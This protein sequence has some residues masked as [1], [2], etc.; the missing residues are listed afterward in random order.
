[1]G[2]T[3]NQK[4][5]A[6]KNE[7]KRKRI[8]IIESQK[9]KEQVENAFE[10]CFIPSYNERIHGAIPV[11]KIKPFTNRRCPNCA[12]YPTLKTRHKMCYDHFP[13]VPSCEDCKFSKRKYE[14]LTTSE[15][16]QAKVTEEVEFFKTLPED[17]KQRKEMIRSRRRKIKE[18]ND[19]ERIYHGPP[20]WTD[21]DKQK[22]EER[23]KQ[24]TRKFNRESAQRSKIYLAAR[25]KYTREKAYLKTKQ[26]N[27]TKFII[28]TKINL[29]LKKDIANMTQNIKDL[30]KTLDDTIKQ[31]QSAD[32][33]L[34]LHMILQNDEYSNHSNDNHAFSSFPSQ[35]PPQSEG[36]IEK[37]PE[38]PTNTTNNEDHGTDSQPARNYK[39]PNNI[40]DLIINEVYNM[41]I[42]GC[43][44]MD[45]NTQDSTNIGIIMEN[46]NELIPTIP[47]ETPLI[48]DTQKFTGQEEEV[49]IS[50]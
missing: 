27:N 29:Q 6:I 26:T 23:Q 44:D 2:N 45:D 30:Q 34:L 5:N 12:K 48:Q 9:I 33:E 10:K 24:L 50:P 49:T 8:E 18:K 31:F 35:S 46:I 3:K 13:P 4:K 47:F 15:I 37:L 21:D 19:K 22:E 41:D 32:E 7:K 38:H 40:N 42:F 17:D 25:T 11:C 39:S 20:L 28:Q 1:M 43:I 36:N 14:L 16:F